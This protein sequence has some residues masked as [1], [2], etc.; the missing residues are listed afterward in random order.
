MKRASYLDIPFVPAGHEDPQVPAVWKKALFQKGVF[1]YGTIQ[2]VNWS[3]LPAG[4]KFARHYHEDMQELFV[5]IS[6]EVQ[7]TA[8]DE[9][10]TLQRGDAVIVEPREAHQ[11]Y[12]AGKQDAE[13][14]AIGLAPNTGGQ[15]VVIGEKDPA[16]AAKPARA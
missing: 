16:A 5:I 11:M 10:V 14:L 12:N 13:Y 9:T 2:M 6:G 3:R 1:Q 15:T 4:Q 7:M 8:G